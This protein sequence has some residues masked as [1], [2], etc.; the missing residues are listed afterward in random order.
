MALGHAG[1]SERPAGV[2]DSVEGARHQDE[3]AGR[4]PRRG[5]ARA[6]PPRC[7]GRRP[8]R[9]AAAI[10]SATLGRELRTL[11][12]PAA[13]HDVGDRR[14]RGHHAVEVLVRRDGE[15]QVHPVPGER[16]ARASAR[17][18]PRRPGCVRRPATSSGR[19][20]ITSSR[21]GIRERPIAPRSRR[22]ERVTE[23]A[24]DRDDRGDRRSAPRARRTSART[25]RRRPRH[26]IDAELLTAD[27]RDTGPDL[28][29]APLE[30]DVAP[31]SAARASITRSASVRL[32]AH[33]RDLA[34]LDD[35]RLLVATSRIVEP[36]SGWSSADLADH[37]DVARHKVVA[38]HD[39]P[40]PTSYDRQ[41]HRLVRE[42]EERERRERLEVGRPRVAPAR[43]RRRGTAEVRALLGELLHGDL[44][45]RRPAALGHRLQ[46]RRGVEAG[47]D[48]VRARELG[49][50]HA[51]SSSCRSSRSR[52]SSDR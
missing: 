16:L 50:P 41:P 23:D 36:S 24:L 19:P 2:R 12:F 17:A 28:P 37:R 18:P 4:R 31:T 13:Y 38:S 51:R 46:V 48:P 22:I 27:G 30:E 34:R 45:P 40:M 14:E 33:D 25:G 8:G 6:R 20:G 32:L 3:V 49:A 1:S 9:P 26:A 15:H 10:R 29:V 42:P 7:P 35:P 21:P 39:P 44:A 5:P 11:S 47:R 52:G 43:R